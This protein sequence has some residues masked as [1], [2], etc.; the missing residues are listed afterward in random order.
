MSIV[1]Y[2]GDNTHNAPSPALWGS[3]LVED[4]QSRGRLCIISEDHFVDLPTGKYTATQAGGVGTF[5]LIDFAYGVAVAAAGHTDDGDGINIQQGGTAGEWVLPAAGVTVALE[6]RLK[7]VTA[8]PDFFLGVSIT[9]TTIIAASAMTPANYLGF[10]SL[11]GDS[12]IKFAGSKAA[13]ATSVQS[14]SGTAL[15]TATF[16]KL[17]FKVELD[18]NG[19]GAAY[20][21]VNGVKD[22]TYTIVNANVP[23]VEMRPSLVCQ[24]CGTGEPAVYVDR[25]RTGVTYA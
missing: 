1:Q 3:F 9:D 23:I 17:G 10:I 21:Y 14:N 20:Q 12:I 8:H 5:A 18:G 11:T 6:A 7:F 15:T 4:A 13:A 19:A 16:Y 2:Y 25:I 22:R 24:S